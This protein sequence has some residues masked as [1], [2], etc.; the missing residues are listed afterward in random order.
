MRLERRRRGWGRRLGHRGDVSIVNFRGRGGSFDQ[1]LPSL[2]LDPGGGRL[3]LGGESFALVERPATG[4]VSK[5]LKVLGA[6]AVVLG[7]TGRMR[8]RKRPFPRPLDLLVAVDGWQS[9]R[10]AWRRVGMMRM[11]NGR[12]QLSLPWMKGIPQVTDGRQLDRPDVRII[13]TT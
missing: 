1:V 13:L 4:D 12:Q 11:Q 5:V 3:R 7:L 8:V 10:A 2:A 6:V 9:R